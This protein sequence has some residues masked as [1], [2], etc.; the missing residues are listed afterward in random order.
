[1]QYS[2]VQYSFPSQAG[3]VAEQLQELFVESQMFPRDGS[4][5][6][7]KFLE[8]RHSPSI[9]SHRAPVFLPSQ[10]LNE[11]H[12]HTPSTQTSPA[13]LQSDRFWPLQCISI[14]KITMISRGEVW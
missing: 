10:E 9:G 8:Q 6:D 3:A 7:I 2:R 5:H 13:T 11:P 1:M 14:K 12:L 4:A